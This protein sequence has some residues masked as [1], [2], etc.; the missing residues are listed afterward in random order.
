MHIKLI[1]NILKF[2]L[3]LTL[4]ASFNSTAFAADI[5]KCGALKGYVNFHHHGL[6][7][8]N[9]SGFSEDTISGAMTSLVKTPSGNYDILLIDAANTIKSFIADGGKISLFRKGARD[10]TLMH[11]SPA[12]VIEIYTFWED[13][14]GSYKYDLMTSKGGDGIPIH[15]S[16]LLTG[17]CEFIDFAAIN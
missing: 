7:P 1:Q 12:G 10:A 9:K 6:V 11:L 2:G 17:D 8:K 16:R 13:G 14:D 15:L 3:A 5:A 4:I